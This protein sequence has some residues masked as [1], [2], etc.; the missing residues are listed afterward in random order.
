M[1]LL[2]VA[3]LALTVSPL[4]LAQGAPNQLVTFKTSLGDIEVTL[5][6]SIAPKTVANFLNYV[7]KQ[8]YD[9]TFIHRP[10]ASRL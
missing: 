3:A 6:P 7:N 9:N 1:D 8:A 2:R 10:C 4:L 5:Y